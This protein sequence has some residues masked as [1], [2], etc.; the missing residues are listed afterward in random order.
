MKIS[1]IIYNQRIHTIILERRN[2]VIYSRVICLQIAKL[3]EQY[4]SAQNSNKCKQKI[5]CV[6]LSM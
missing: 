4:I 6:T 1:N 2:H 3:H 5:T